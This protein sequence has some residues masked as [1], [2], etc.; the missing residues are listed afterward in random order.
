ML[1]KLFTQTK[2]N[3]SP[4]CGAFCFSG[5]ELKRFLSERNPAVPMF[6][7]WPQI[8]LRCEAIEML[9]HRGNSGEA[10]VSGYFIQRGV[11]AGS[12]KNANSLQNLRLTLCHRIARQSFL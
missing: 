4:L 2:S 10:N 11:E 1:A 9:P 3:A 12:G 5:C 6:L 7:A 8:A